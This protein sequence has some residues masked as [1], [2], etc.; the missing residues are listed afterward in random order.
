MTACPTCRGTGEVPA[1]VAAALAA[2]DWPAG[3]GGHRG[4]TCHCDGPAHTWT[5]GW[6]P[7]D[8]PKP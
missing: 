6:C 5:P 8:G 3:G 2:V 1:H 7:A 4:R